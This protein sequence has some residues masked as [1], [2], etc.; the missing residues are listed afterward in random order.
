MK[1][2]LPLIL[3]VL[4]L[5]SG[6]AGTSGQTEPSSEPMESTGQTETHT[7]AAMDF[8][9][10]DAEGNPV[11]LSDFYGKPIVLNFWASWCGP[12]K[13]EMPEFEEVYREMG[14]QVQFLMINLT[15]GNETMDSAQSFV[16][17]QGYTFPVYYDT[18]GNAAFVYKITSIPATFVI[19]AEGNIAGYAVGAIS[20]ET[21][22]S[23][24]N[25][26]TGS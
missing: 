3:L 13:G 20:K 26:V 7:V 18:S 2:L 14:D 10:Y 6:C 5:F 23:G 21:L 9:V 25:M 17:S 1:R 11:K 15:Y 4:L 24:I 12:C 22:H 19:D 8:T 16:S